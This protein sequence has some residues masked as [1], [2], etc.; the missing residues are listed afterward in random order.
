MRRP[1]Q[2]EDVKKKFHAKARKMRSHGIRQLCL[3]QWQRRGKGWRQPQQ[4]QW[5]R[6]ESK[7]TSETPPRT[8]HGGAQRGSL[9]LC[10]AGLLAENRKSGISGKRHR[11]KPIPWEKNSLGKLEDEE[12]EEREPAIERRREYADLGLDLCKRE[13]QVVCHASALAL[14]MT[15]EGRREAEM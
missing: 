7:R 1:G 11:L 6:K 3:G 5:R 9:W 13:E 8:W 2:I 4:V 15:D 12:D 14:A 10:Y